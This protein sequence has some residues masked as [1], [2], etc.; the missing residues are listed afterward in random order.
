M[1]NQPITHP[2]P[3]SRLTHHSHN[4][5]LAVADAPLNPAATVRPRAG[6]AVLVHVKLVVVSLAGQE[7]AREARPDLA[8]P[9]RFV[10]FRF[11]CFVCYVSGAARRHEREQSAERRQSGAEKSGATAVVPRLVDNSPPTTKR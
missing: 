8:V 10:S 3:L 9:C 6:A 7:G 4:D 2:T 11:V 1:T 5:R